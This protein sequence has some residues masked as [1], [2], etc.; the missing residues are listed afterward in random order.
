M[1]VSKTIGIVLDMLRS[2]QFVVRLLCLLLALLADS[3]AVHID[4][5]WSKVQR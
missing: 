5:V 1:S 4:C 3:N 2:I